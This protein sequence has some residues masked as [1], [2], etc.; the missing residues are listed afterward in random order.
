MTGINFKKCLHF[1]KESYTNN[2]GGYKPIEMASRVKVNKCVSAGIRLR[3]IIPL[4]GRGG[5][6]IIIAKDHLRANPKIINRD[7]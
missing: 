3:F 1:A 7:I 5:L 6:E 2:A 4:I